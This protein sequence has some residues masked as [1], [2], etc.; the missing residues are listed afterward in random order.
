MSEIVQETTALGKMI[1][2]IQKALRNPA[3]S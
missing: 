2:A 1:R 3:D